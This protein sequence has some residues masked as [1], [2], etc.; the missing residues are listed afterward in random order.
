MVNNSVTETSKCFINTTHTHTHVRSV[1]CLTSITTVSVFPRYPLYISV[2]LEDGI[3][4]LCHKLNIQFCLHDERS[5]S[6]LEA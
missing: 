1:I 2:V 3:I 5:L 4:V 6:A